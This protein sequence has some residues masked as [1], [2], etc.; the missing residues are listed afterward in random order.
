MYLSLANK[1]GCLG[2]PGNKQKTMN[3]AKNHTL[4][5]PLMPVTVTHEREANKDYQTASLVLVIVRSVK[6]SK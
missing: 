1:Q 6:R 2:M 4:G 3:K 5:W